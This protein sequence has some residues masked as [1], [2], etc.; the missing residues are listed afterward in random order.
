M[1]ILS[2]LLGVLVVLA[3]TAVTG[4]FVAQEFAYMAVDRSALNA[5]AA[6]IFR[7][8]LN[9]RRCVSCARHYAELA[10]RRGMRSEA[11]FALEQLVS[12]APQDVDAWFELGRVREDLGRKRDAGEAFR[13][14]ARL[15]PDEERGWY[16]LARMHMDLGEYAYALP[17]LRRLS[18]LLPL[19]PQ[20]HYL[21]GVCQQRC[22]NEA[23]VREA[24]RRLVDLDPMRAAQLIE[25]TGYA[26]LRCLLPP[27]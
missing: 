7:Q 22:G 16:G 10:I 6:A 15:Q 18:E 2:L 3:I 12:W 5:R 11:A 1:W 25:E 21:I 20:P 23:A 26:R 24:V 14:A 8:L 4:Y 17:P 13:Q 9:L 27:A 19:S